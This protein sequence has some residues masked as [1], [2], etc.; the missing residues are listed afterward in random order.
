MLIGLNDICDMAEQRGSSIVAFNTPSFE[1][2]RAAIDAA[3]MTDEPIII[4]HAEEHEAFAPIKY[5]GPAIVKL[6]ERSSAKICVHLDHASHLDV[7]AD[8]LNMGFTGVMYDGSNLSYEENLLNS[9][10]A[11][12]MCHSQGIGIECELGSMGSREAGSRVEGGTSEEAGAIYTDPDQAID[13]INKTN[14]DALACSF[15]TVHGLYKGVPHLNLDIPRTIRNRVMVPLVMHGGSGITDDDYR[16]CIKAGIRKINYYTYGATAAGEA[17]FDW[18]QDPK[19]KPLF[20]H[21]ITNQAY[22]A[23]LNNFVHMIKVCT[24]LSE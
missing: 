14:L 19:H 11:A 10:R 5:F 23:L 2:I 21:D 17:T 20:W 24:G 15:G 16:R 7:I 4:A 6:C 12:R 18:V 8:A 3:E 9:Q 13:F 1:A 22:H